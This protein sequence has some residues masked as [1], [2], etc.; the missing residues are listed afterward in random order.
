MSQP[1]VPSTTYEDALHAGKFAYTQLVPLLRQGHSSGCRLFT[2]RLLGETY[3]A[4]VN[5]SMN[6][7]AIKTVTAVAKAL[8][9]IAIKAASVIGI[10]IIILT[11]SD[12]VIELWDPLVQRIINIVSLQ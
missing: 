6:K 1:T 7:I 8:T 9:K 3:K 5:H 10:V 11:I 2:T 4:A 12:L